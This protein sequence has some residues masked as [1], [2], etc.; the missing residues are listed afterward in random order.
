V[1]ISRTFLA[2]AVAGACALGFGAAS[3]TGVTHQAAAHRPAGVAGRATLTAALAH[4]TATP[5]DPIFMNFQGISGEVNA[6]GHLGWIAVDTYR[7]SFSATPLPAGRP[8]V[9]ARM[10]SLVVTT[11]YSKAI[12]PLLARL[13]SGKHT[14]TVKLQAVGM[15]DTGAPTTYLTLTLDNVFISGIQETSSGE[16]PEET[17]VLQAAQLAV[18][19]TAADGATT[20]FCFNFASGKAC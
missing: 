2:A 11:P 1:P 20:A 10:G 15:S 8:G 5:G 14:P 7:T 4:G 16:R 6:A 9:R 19:Y 18:H 3:L 17:L 13:V 12:P